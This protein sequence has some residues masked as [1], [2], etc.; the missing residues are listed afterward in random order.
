[1]TTTLDPVRYPIGQFDWGQAIT[2]A[3][4]RDDIAAIVAVP[5]TVRAAV[6]GLSDA[7]L[8]TP[9]REGGWTPR[10]V[11]HHI[12]DSHMNAY[13]RYKLALTEQIPTIK[14]YEESAWAEVIDARIAPV[15]SSLSL[16]DG[17][18]ARWGVLLGYMTDEDFAK[19]FYHPDHKREISLDSITALYGWHS[20]HH[21]AQVTSLRERMGWR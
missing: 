4:R 6:H 2:Q 20:R 10:Q 21:P 3:T 8:D 13:I 18:H 5:A 16:I 14:P 7:Q 1:M 9:Y 17:L 19:T 12:A 11:V 15:E